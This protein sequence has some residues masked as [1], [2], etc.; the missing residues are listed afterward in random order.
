METQSVTSNSIPF[1]D[2]S[3]EFVFEFSQPDYSK[4]NL[5]EKAQL[6]WKATQAAGAR[7]EGKTIKERFKERFWDYSKGQATGY[8][9]GF[10][11]WLENWLNPTSGLYRNTPG[12]I[13]RQ[14]ESADEDIL[15]FLIEY[16]EGDWERRG[17]VAGEATG[18]AVLW[19]LETYFY[20]K[21]F[22]RSLL[23]AIK[24]L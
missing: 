21:K 24:K 19:G 7:E 16:M 4:L 8:L 2:P 3:Q 10:V 9:R 15:E 12:E 18:R 11:H 17:E 1:H 5:K 20:V 14:I 13:L 22:P 6:F 23:G